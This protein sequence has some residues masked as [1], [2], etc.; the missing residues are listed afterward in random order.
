M[1]SIC[2]KGSGG[3]LSSNVSVRYGL[4]STGEAFDYV[5]GHWAVSV[6]RFSRG[7]LRHRS[8]PTLFAQFKCRWPASVRVR[9]VL[10]KRLR[11]L[12]L[13]GCLRF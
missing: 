9:H 8:G 7:L 11:P 1:R 3:V 6:P 13:T 2:S 4:I 5:R 12:A 10:A